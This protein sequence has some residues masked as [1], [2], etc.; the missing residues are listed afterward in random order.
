MITEAI[1]KARSD[2]T[3]VFHREAWDA[4]CPQHKPQLVHIGDRTAELNQ[5]NRR[6]AELEA[7]VARLKGR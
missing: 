3:I 1:Y 7:E 5:R 6:V 2:Q 4:N